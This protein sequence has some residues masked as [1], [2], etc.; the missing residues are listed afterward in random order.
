MLNVLHSFFIFDFRFDYSQW[1]SVLLYMN[2]YSLK[3]RNLNII[4]FLVLL[5]NFCQ[6]LL[7]KNWTGTLQ[8]IRN[9]K[10]WSC[11]YCG[12]SM[13]GGLT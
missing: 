5:G 4:T 9:N 10:D 6:I 11:N 2:S 13:H 8:T 7:Q 1:F 12:K 3:S